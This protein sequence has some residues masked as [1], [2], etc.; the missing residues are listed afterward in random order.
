MGPAPLVLVRPLLSPVKPQ[1]EL[2]QEVSTTGGDLNEVSGRHALPLLTKLFRQWF[3]VLLTQVAV[4][5][6]VPDRLLRLLLAATGFARF[7]R[8]EWVR[9][10]EFP[11]PSHESPSTQNEHGQPSHAPTRGRR[12]APIGSRRLSA[13]PAGFG[14]L[15]QLLHCPLSALNPARR[16]SIPWAAGGP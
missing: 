10:P 2:V 6:P 14:S 8:A 4:T 1:R 12:L 13:R 5:L 15:A 3:P 16:L 7:R 9:L 11:S